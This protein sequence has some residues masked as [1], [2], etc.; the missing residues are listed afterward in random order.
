MHLR[1][2]IAL[3]VI[4]AFAVAAPSR[5]QE[6]APPI[7][8]E[9]LFAPPAPEEPAAE[10]APE[11]S[12]PADAAPSVPEA[13]PETPPAPVE[14]PAPAATQLAA[15]PAH[16]TVAER[17]GLFGLGLVVAPKLGGGLG[18]VTLAGLGGTLAA[19]LELGWSLPIK[20]PLGRDLQA[21]TV[22]GY[23]GPSSSAT[24]DGDPRLP[25]G[26]FSYTLTVHQLDVVWGGLYRIPVEAVP[27]LRPYVLAGLRTVWSW[28]VIGGEAGGEPFG[29]YVESAFD[30][31]AALT[32]G[33]DFY[34]GPGALL[35]ELQT[36]VGYADRFV[37]RDTSVLGFEGA[38]GYRFFL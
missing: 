28:T 12:S 33:A 30:L 25:D 38:V 35:L 4:T 34:F 31:G 21:T 3:A 37:L 29:T 7:D 32:L 2:L 16:G 20:L 5:A 6:R 17:G 15:P 10:P 9:D 26:S 19:Q 23:S 8:V 14:A 18:N 22:I 24:V 13:S 1:Y 27:W 36:T 11:P